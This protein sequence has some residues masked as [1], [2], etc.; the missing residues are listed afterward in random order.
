MTA[1]D[2]QRP[3]VRIW[4]HPVAS[5]GVCKLANTRTP[6]P[7]RRPRPTIALT[8]QRKRS[9][10]ADLTNVSEIGGRG[11]A[12][13]TNVS[14]IGGR[15]HADLT[16]V[17]KIGGPGSRLTRL[18]PRVGVG[19]QIP[20]RQSTPRHGPPGAPGHPKIKSIM[21]ISRNPAGTAPLWVTDSGNRKT[22][23]PTTTSRF[24]RA[25]RKN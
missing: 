2:Q 18:G 7:K 5:G 20:T 25:I 15:G 9:Q 10:T 14:K 12:D 24:R 11:S 22:E 23:A 16:N 3:A 19:A 8:P 1:N 13:L 21:S 17:S 6:Q 4:W